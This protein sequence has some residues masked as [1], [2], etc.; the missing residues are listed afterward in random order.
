MF[1][2]K[3]GAARVSERDLFS[4]ASAFMIDFELDGKSLTVP[5]GTTIIEA[6]D[7]AGVYIPRFC[8]HKKL[9]VAAN[10]RMCL[11][12]V[13]KSGKPLPACATPVTAGM[14]AFTKT[15]KA[16]KA[17]R[18]VM[19]FLLI[20][21][22]LD[23]PICDQGG[24]CE[25]QDLS[26]EFG[27]S[28]SSY[29]QPK[30]AVHSDDIGPLIETEM[31]RCIQCTRCVRFGEE[32]AGLRELGVVNRGEKEEITTYVK[33]FLKSEMSGNIID[34]CPVGALTNKPARYEVRGWE[35]KEHPSI[36]MHDCVGTNLYLHTRYS[37]ETK[38]NKVFRAVPKKNE[39]IN[40]VWMSDRDRF[41]VEALYHA[42]RVTKPQMKKKN[43]W[44]E[45]EWQYALD[46]I[47]HLTAHI[48]KEKGVNQIA[49]LAGYTSTVEEYYIF[50]KYIR[51]LGSP[52][53]DHRI[54][55]MDFS[56]Q[57]SRES[58]PVFSKCISDIENADALLLIGSNVRQEQPILSTRIF[59]ST[60]DQL[61]V[62]A[63]NPIDHP[64]VFPLSEKIIHADVIDS[65]AQVVKVI[66]LAKK[67]MITGLENITPSKA[68]QTMAEKLLFAQS[69]MIFLGAHALHHPNAAVIRQ[70]TY[71]LEKW[72]GSAVAYLT[73]G[74][75]SA[76]AWMA[77][78][79][80]HRGVAGISVK[81]MG[82]DAKTLLCDHP[83]S[84]YFLF[85]F[86]P[87]FDCAYTERALQALS[88]AEL[89]VCFSMFTTEK[90][91]EYA[92]FIL[93]ITP[94]SEMDG[95]FVNMCGTWQ[96]FQ[97]AS[98]P[99]GDAKP[100]WKVLRA[101]ATLSHLSGFSYQNIAAIGD[102][103]KKQLDNH[104]SATARSTSITLP[105]FNDKIVVPEWSLYR[106]NALV[107]RAKALQEL[108]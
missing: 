35:V 74:A 95:T 72:L 93:P 54:R 43:Q 17:Q 68:A 105:T 85:N 108:V 83:V 24:E 84:A 75:N 66:A 25:L 94:F 34:I 12:E 1:I 59:K 76:G 90:M 71:C 99:M 32:V 29:H 33:H 89:V 53:V 45:V 88:N 4:G 5:E 8:Y 18:D 60:Q 21:H 79:V 22:P 26:M 40:E 92:D 37:D 30:R 16:M 104:F 77:G 41:S 31:T 19:E 51:A 50:Q 78:C 3:Q 9:S 102:T 87:E 65:L 6:A 101:L 27:A 106:D 69:P 57:S 80:P 55:E 67:E 49:G 100:G 98:T 39:S 38:E 91:R 15:E 28:H 103:I 47:A 56:D 42:D 61:R 81:T 11:V 2:N 10:C 62:M 58:M 73:D 20:N 46:A 96:S 36:S 86:E 97:A 14:K 64:F 107:R 82:S 7:D 23:C 44:V 63:I 70:L 52:H 13:E 48:Q